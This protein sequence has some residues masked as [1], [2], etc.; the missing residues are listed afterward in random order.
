MPLVTPEEPLHCGDTPT[1][2]L[3]GD[4][5][6]QGSVIS[7]LIFLAKVELPGVA[8]VLLPRPVCAVFPVLWPWSLT[9]GF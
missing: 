7:Q 4:C 9:A 2:I 6:R 5:H 3:G 1:V 8:T